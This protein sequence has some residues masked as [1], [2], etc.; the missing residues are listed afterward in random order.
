MSDLLLP[1]SAVRPTYEC[2]CGKMFYSV[3]AGQ[4]H[5]AGCKEADEIIRQDQAQKEER[6]DA[7]KGWADPEAR[8]WI[9]KRVSEGKPAT[10]RGRPA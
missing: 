2:L 1:S 10:K 4:R 3:S 9:D 8:E 7:F 5:A 6:T